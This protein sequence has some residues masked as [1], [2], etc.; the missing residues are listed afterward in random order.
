MALR[1]NLLGRP[2]AELEGATIPGPR[3]R[4]AW[5]LLAILLLADRPPSRRSLADLLFADATDPLGA[6]R[7]TLSQLRTGLRGSVIVDGDPVV[8]V[9]GS[10]A[11][12]DVL[13]VLGADQSDHAGFAGPQ[14]SLLDGADGL[15]GP[16][17]DLWL[18]AARHRID[19]AR[20]AALRRAADHALAD[21]QPS[22]AVV[23]STNALLVEP[24][25]PGGR[26]T[27]VSSLVAA[28]DH[29]NALAQLREWSMWI[30]TDLRI[31]QLVSGARRS[32]GGETNRRTDVRWR[33]R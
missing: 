5:A 21:G 15:A 7:W 20:G 19:Q 3:G 6:L 13:D 1:I 16:E 10:S 28:G 33:G 23:A 26:A 31:R 24:D 14:Q 12:V 9:L 2:C 17:F 8:V 11:T 18:T 32:P 29:V 4:K 30:R 27:L 22:A 25:E